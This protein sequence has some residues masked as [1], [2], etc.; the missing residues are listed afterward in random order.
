MP[1]G[2]HCHRNVIYMV[3]LVNVLLYCLIDVFKWNIKNIEIR[4]L[5]QR[6][7]ASVQQV[8]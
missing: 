4:V 2:H 5:L 7:E 1:P 8:I 3:G 6:N